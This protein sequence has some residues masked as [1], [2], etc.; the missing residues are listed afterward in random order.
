MAAF[1]Q[2]FENFNGGAASGPSAE[3]GDDDRKADSIEMLAE[4]MERFLRGK[5][6]LR[7]I[8][9]RTVPGEPISAEKDER[10]GVSRACSVCV[11]KNVAHCGAEG[12]GDPVCYGRSGAA[13]AY[14]KKG[15]FRVH[16]K[17]PLKM[18]KRGL[19]S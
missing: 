1:A 8:A 4:K 15:G 18:E 10:R 9:A 5:L 11:A 7:N 13:N 2:M 19:R 3:S 16:L 17:N 14:Q 12:S 6:G